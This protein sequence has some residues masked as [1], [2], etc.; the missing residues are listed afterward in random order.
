MTP[1]QTKQKNLLE[2]LQEGTV[3]LFLDARYEGVEVPERL[4]KDPGLRLNVDYA[5]KIPDFEV[6]EDAIRATLSF[7]QRPY[8]CVIPMEA[9]WQMMSLST[10]KIAVF[11]TSFPKEMIREMLLTDSQL[12]EGMRELLEEIAKTPNPTPK[13]LADAKNAKPLISVVSPE[14]SPDAPEETPSETPPEPPTPPKRGH[15]KLVK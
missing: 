13:I 4:R 6:S 1:N 3:M 9:I 5:F 10:K 11:P 12:P 2:L 8:Y 14:A 15:L 7:S